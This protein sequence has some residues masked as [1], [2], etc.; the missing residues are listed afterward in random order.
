MKQGTS[1]KLAYLANGG[2]AVC[3][4]IIGT[5]LYINNTQSDDPSS[6]P[7][8]Q[9]VAAA[10]AS[11]TPGTEAAQVIADPATRSEEL[12]TRTRQLDEIE[13]Q[14]S[15][16]SAELE[17]LENLIEDR[18]FQLKEIEATLAKKGI[19]L[20]KVVSA[21]RTADYQMLATLDEKMQ[22]FMG[23]DADIVPAKLGPGAPGAGMPSATLNADIR[24]IGEIIQKARVD[25]NPAANSAT[26]SLLVEIH[27]EV[28]S[29][30]LSI[31]GQTRAMAAAQ[32]ISE[33]SLQAIRIEAHSDTTGPAEVNTRLSAE[34]A[35]AVARVFAEAGIPNS[36][37]QIVA[38]GEDPEGLPVATP[39]GTPEPLNRTVGVYPI[40]L[41]N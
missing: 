32:V 34:R 22:D 1:R 24:K 7:A 17:D 14:I 37:I 21:L 33:M 6:T 13:L 36:A 35:E 40:A 8:D 39:D 16:R 9:Q 28:G 12:A 38:M 31:G 25:A 27:F 23:S 15:E 41:T 2:A 18:R 10:V 11:A 30:D 5:V 29:A 4:V 19:E 3:A 26:E 20:D